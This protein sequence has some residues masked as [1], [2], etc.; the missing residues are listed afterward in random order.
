MDYVMYELAKTCVLQENNK[1]ANKQE[2]TS[3]S[4][5]KKTQ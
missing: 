2:L 5:Y 4:I 3:Q 1:N